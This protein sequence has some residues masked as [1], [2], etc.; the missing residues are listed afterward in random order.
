M[1]RRTTIILAALALKLAADPFPIMSGVAVATVAQAPAVR[2]GADPKVVA[3]F[4]DRVNEYVALHQK[5]ERAL[6][7]LSNEATPQEID[8]NQR[9][10]GEQLA[11]ARRAAKQG[12]VFTLEMQAY[13]RRLLARVFAGPAGKQLLASIMDENP[14]KISLRVNQRYPDTVPLST[15]PPE[16]LEALPKLPEEIEYRF[17]WDQ[18]ILLDPHAYIIIDLVPNAIPGLALATADAVAD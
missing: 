9:A 10:L 8:R 12:D 17:V 13:V 14:A 2:A 5:F 16:V 3:A 6:P 11:N 15:M 7:R 18:L 1:N 4:L